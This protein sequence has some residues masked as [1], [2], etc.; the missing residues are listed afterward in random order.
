LFGGGLVIFCWPLQ[1]RFLLDVRRKA[2]SAAFDG[3]AFDIFPARLD[4]LEMT[5]LA[6]VPLEHA[7]EAGAPFM[8]GCAPPAQFRPGVLTAARRTQA[9]VIRGELA[10]L[11]ERVHGRTRV[12]AGLTP[13][14]TLQHR[15]GQQEAVPGDALEPARLIE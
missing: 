9:A 8:A 15:D 13:P 12:V 4:A 5:D 14:T 10:C 1:R 11:V 7:L 6:P 2:A 3:R